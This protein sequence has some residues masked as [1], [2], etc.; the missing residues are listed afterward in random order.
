M[1]SAFGCK[2]IELT[3]QKLKVA[4]FLCGFKGTFIFFLN[5]IILLILRQKVHWVVYIYFNLYPDYWNMEDNKEVT[6]LLLLISC[7]ILFFVCFCLIW[8][9]LKK[10]GDFGTHYWSTCTKGIL[11]MNVFNIMLQLHLASSMIPQ[12]V[13]SWSLL[14]CWGLWNLWWVLRSSLL[15]H[16]PLRHCCPTW[17]IGH[18]ESEGGKM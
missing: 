15:S 6:V 3:W 8:S 9:N 14:N 4:S 1:L 18:Y 10:K 5:E 2:I 7:L 11:S 16:V 12:S 13:V 17:H